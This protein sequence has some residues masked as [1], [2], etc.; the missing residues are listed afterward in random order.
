MYRKAS[1]QE[2]PPAT[3]AKRI[4]SLGSSLFTERLMVHANDMANLMHHVTPIEHAVAPTCQSAE[5]PEVWQN[6][7]AIRMQIP[8]DLLK[9]KESKKRTLKTSKNPKSLNPKA[10]P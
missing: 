8:S 9:L 7:P 4:S 3:P 10:K 6:A 2:A 1:K 5:E